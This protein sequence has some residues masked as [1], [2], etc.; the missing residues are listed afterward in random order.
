M[1]AQMQA[2]REETIYS[3]VIASAP[4][5]R[6]AAPDYLKRHVVNQERLLIRQA[7]TGLQKVPS[8]TKNYAERT[9]SITGSIESPFFQPPVITSGLGGRRWFTIVNLVFLPPVQNPLTEP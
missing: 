8:L 6:D 5:H 4:H 3:L 2:K 1:P 7:S 9:D